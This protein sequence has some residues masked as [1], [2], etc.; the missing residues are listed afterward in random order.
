MYEYAHLGQPC[1]RDVMTITKDHEDD[2]EEH[3]ENALLLTH[4]ADRKRIARNAIDAVFAHIY[5]VLK[6]EKSAEYLDH[7]C[8]ELADNLLD[9]DDCPIFGE[10]LLWKSN[11]FTLTTD[12]A[13]IGILCLK[14]FLSIGV[15]FDPKSLDNYCLIYWLF[16]QK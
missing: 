7:K 16:I 10:S 9:I 4:M 11:Q 2:H 15:H 3:R 14:Q 1:D 5:M 6:N 13:G 8:K 12:D